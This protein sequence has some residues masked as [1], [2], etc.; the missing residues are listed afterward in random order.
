MSLKQKSDFGFIN[1]WTSESG[2]YNSH[3]GKERLLTCFPLFEEPCE[4]EQRWGEG[5]KGTFL[6]VLLWTPKNVSWWSGGKVQFQKTMGLK[7][8]CVKE[9]VK[10]LFKIQSLCSTFGDSSVLCPWRGSRCWR[11]HSF[12]IT[13]WENW[14]SGVLF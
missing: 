7:H 11:R 5:E 2:P 8:K 6:S 12:T 13:V 4:E 1:L 10:W 14:A 9:Y 3:E